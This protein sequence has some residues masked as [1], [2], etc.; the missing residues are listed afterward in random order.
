[1]PFTGSFMDL[2]ILIIRASLVAQLV[3]NL[4]AVQKTACNIGDPAF[5]SWVR[6]IPWRK[7]WQPAPG[8]LPGKSHGQRNLVGYSPGHKELDTTEAT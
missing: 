7:K 4:L 8:F 6:K 2:V 1:M 3:K 5:N